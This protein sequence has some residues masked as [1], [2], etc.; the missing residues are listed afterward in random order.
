MEEN[1]LQLLILSI[2]GNRYGIDID[3]IAQLMNVDTTQSTVSFE[4]LME[5]A[6]FP[7]CNYSNALQIKEKTGTSILISQPD[8]V[9]VVSIADICRVPNILM[10]AA[11]KKG[12]WGL[13]PQEHGMIILIDFYK[14]EQFQRLTSSKNKI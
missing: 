12:V 2:G 8:E 5:K 13:W 14:N 4:Q 11:E 1:K 6:S 3:Q 9:A 10:A 7:E